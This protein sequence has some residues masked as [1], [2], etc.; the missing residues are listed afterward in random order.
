MKRVLL[1]GFLALSAPVM[2]KPVNLMVFGDS[3]SVGHKI[4]PQDSY[5][6]KLEQALLKDKYQVKIIN[7]SKS[8]ETTGGAVA[9]M[10]SALKHKPAGVI[11]QLGSNDAFQKVPLDDTKKNLA[12][13]IEFFQ[14][15][16][17][18]VMLFG[19]E[20]PVALPAEYRAGVRQMYDDLALD[21]ELLLYPFFMDGL[22]N[23]DGTHKKADYFLEDKIHPSAKGVDI[24]VRRTLPA[25]KQFLFE[26]MMVDGPRQK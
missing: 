4:Q 10:K 26:D 13:L 6:S 20:V 17:V 16:D 11:L 15:N 18:P 1:A 19:M 7:F 9:K 5:C 21:N 8:G 22:W 23:E 2:A 25:V 12:T 3:L 24:M 14:Q